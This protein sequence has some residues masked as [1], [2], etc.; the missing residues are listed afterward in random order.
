MS[1]F[2]NAIFENNRLIIEA[3]YNAI[4]KCYNPLLTEFHHMCQY[5]TAG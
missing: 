1:Y 3:Q 4:E 5:L 2:E